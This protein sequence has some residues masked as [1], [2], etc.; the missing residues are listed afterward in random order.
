MSNHRG[1]DL[2][3]ASV[4]RR[5]FLLGSLAASLGVTAA[6]GT[7]LLLSSTPAR[8]AERFPVD[9][10]GDYSFIDSGTGCEVRVTVR[11]GVRRIR[12]NGLPNHS[13]G[14]F[15]NSRNPNSISAQSY[16]YSFPT[17]PARS[18]SAQGYVIP[19]SFGIAVNG[20]LFDPIAAEWYQNDRNSG[21]NLNPL[22]PKVN[23]GLDHNHAHVQPTGAYHYHG[24]P[25]GLADQID[26]GRH[27]PLIGWAG[28]GFPIYLDRGYRS[29]RDKGSGVK[30]LTSSFRLKK[31]TRPSGP[32]GAYDGTYVEDYEYV[33]GAGD[34][35]EAN[36]RVQVTPEF[37]RG[38]Y[39]YIL[40]EEFPVI[41]RAFVGSV[42]TSFAKTGPGGA[43]GQGGQ[44]PGGQAPGGQR[45]GAGGQRPDGPPPGGP[46]GQR[47]PRPPRR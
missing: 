33:A 21:W 2:T 29:A 44:R 31:G 10:M 41:P 36:G 34:L 46:G 3:T 12:S 16:D 6:G 14:Q 18:R 43:G 1:T 15:P 5:G 42:A 24:I 37:P 26:T 30:Q 27:A 32:G 13:T 35:D 23:L 25:D 47:P 28:D 45:P 9:V 38:T 40:T 8:A 11:N 17:S 4:S 7:A 19:Q 39:C 22:S 20:V